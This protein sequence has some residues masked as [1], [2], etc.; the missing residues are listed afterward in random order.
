MANKN[1]H[2]Q[3]QALADDE[4]Y[5][6]DEELSDF[7]D[8]YMKLVKRC[9]VG[10]G[11]APMMVALEYAV[12]KA[13]GLGEDPPHRVLSPIAAARESKEVISE[14]YENIVDALQ[15]E[16]ENRILD[17]LEQEVSN[18]DKSVSGWKLKLAEYLL[19]GGESGHKRVSTRQFMNHPSRRWLIG[20]CI[21][22]GYVRTVTSA[23]FT[24]EQLEQIDQVEISGSDD[25]DESDDSDEA[26]SN[27]AGGSYI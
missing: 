8:D 13:G 15:K 18:H 19:T 5:V 20:Q 27:A 6:L 16:D 4:D 3:Y 2:E 12:E 26:V 14:N 24:E 17:I 23:E 1:Y 22:K 9:T 7:Y 25:E 11:N 10:V 21:C